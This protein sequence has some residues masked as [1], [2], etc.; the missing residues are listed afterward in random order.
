MFISPFENIT[1]PLLFGAGFQVRYCLTSDVLNGIYIQKSFQ[2]LLL[3]L[4]LVCIPWMLLAKP[5]YLRR[6]YLKK[7]SYGPL[8]ITTCYIFNNPQQHRY[9][10]G[11]VRY[12]K[13]EGI[14]LIEMDST[15]VPAQEKV[16]KVVYGHEPFSFCSLILGM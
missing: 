11:V 2:I 5:W 8:S 9:H 10:Y 1:S 16:L 14:P 4:A 7:V 13:E 6:K 12:N 3:L 15:G